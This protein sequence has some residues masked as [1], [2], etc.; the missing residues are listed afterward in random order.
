MKTKKTNIII[1]LALIF[2]VF[3]YS[4]CDI[5]ELEEEEE[6]AL[7]GIGSSN[8]III[9]NIHINN[10]TT[11]KIEWDT[12]ENI[13]IPIDSFIIYIKKPG[14]ENFD[15]TPFAEP[16]SEDTSLNTDNK[17]AFLTETPL[18]YGFGE[19]EFK[20]SGVYNTGATT[21]HS[22]AFPLTY[23]GL[24]A[25]FS[26]WTNFSG[27]IGQNSFAEP[28]GIIVGPD[29]NIYISDNA[30][31]NNSILCFNSE[32]EYQKS[33]QN[34]VINNISTSFKRPR[35]LASDNF[36]YIYIADTGNDR[37]IRFKPSQG[38]INWESWGTDDIPI[39]ENFHPRNIAI[40]Q[41]TLYVTD[42][43]NNRVI[44]FTFDDN[45]LNLLETSIFIE[46]PSIQ[47]PRGIAVDSDHMIYIL[48]K[49]QITKMLPNGTIL[50]SWGGSPSDPN[51]FSSP[52]SITIDPINNQLYV[53]DT[54]NHRIR[55]SDKN[56]IF[57]AI[58]GK[59][60]TEIGDFNEPLSLFYKNRKLYI[61]DTKNNR[62][63][64][65]IND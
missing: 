65:F 45:N 29:G 1:L 62:I 57:V 13:S 28:S 38:T 21:G 49:S 6:S 47:S 53:A 41:N 26:T 5:V 16:P 27:T 8:V 64:I 37:I 36:G 30:E 51:Q 7:D 59:I 2:S 31:G 63:Q 44:K 34:T 32:G 58:W 54:L 18:D 25:P 40:F 17:F 11:I 60:G 10:N 39:G 43:D 9:S 42:I 35:G 50:E 24:L 61:A 14:A 15:P 12:N 46:A 3:L 56:A 23:H 55:V 52:E 33:Y 4:G 48:E 19:Y 22:L 20:I